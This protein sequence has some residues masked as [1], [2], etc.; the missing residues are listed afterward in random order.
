MERSSVDLAFLELQWLDE[1][2]GGM[3]VGREILGGVC[4]IHLFSV[5]VIF[6]F[7]SAHMP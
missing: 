2:V 3:D 6:P 7:F 4:I 1:M 5:F